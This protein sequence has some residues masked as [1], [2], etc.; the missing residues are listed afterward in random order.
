MKDFEESYD[1]LEKYWL[2]FL[3]YQVY[4]KFWDRVVKSWIRYNKQ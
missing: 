3:M 4:N 2:A 1:T